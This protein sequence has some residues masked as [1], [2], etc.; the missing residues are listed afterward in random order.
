MSLSRAPGKAVKEGSSGWGKGHYCLTEVS[1]HP[2]CTVGTPPRPLVCELEITQMTMLLRRSMWPQEQGSAVH[3]Q[4]PTFH[5][6]RA[7]PPT[8][9]S[10]FP[11]STASIQLRISEFVSRLRKRELFEHNERNLHV[12]R[13][14]PRTKP[15]RQPRDN[16]H[17]VSPLSSRGRPARGFIFYLRIRQLFQLP[18]VK[19]ELL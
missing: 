4:L 3:P 7:Q 6:D 13:T 10:S 5:L 18:H 19:K 8:L 11:V 15:G 16:H 1:K 2:S 14:N 17:N 12:F 9:R